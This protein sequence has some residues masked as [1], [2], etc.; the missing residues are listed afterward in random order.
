M[1]VAG[2]DRRL[3]DSLHLQECGLDL[4]RLDAKTTNFQLVV[5]SSQILDVTLRQTTTAIARAIEP[6]MR[7]ITEWIRNKPFGRQLRSVE[8]PPRHARASDE[9][10]AGRAL[11]H[12]LQVF[13]EQVHLQIGNRNPNHAGSPHV[14]GGQRPIGDV[15]GRFGDAVHVDK[16]RANVAVAGKPGRKARHLELLAAKDHQ[17]QG[18]RTRAVV[19]RIHTHQLLERGGSLIEDRDL[20]GHQQVVERLRRPAH[21]I[22]HDDQTAAIEQGAVDLPHRKIEGDRMKH[23]PDIPLVEMKPGM[24][25]LHEPDDVAMGDEH[26]LRPAG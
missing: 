19:G 20:L 24:R 9:E 8:I 10:F 15:H 14:R 4:S 1:H 16:L 23:R 11:G 17:P 26:T 22:R 6:R 12:G 25:G 2:Y 18:E 5:G 7:I 3:P 21:Q 13:V